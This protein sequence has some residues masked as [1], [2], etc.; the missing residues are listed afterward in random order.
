MAENKRL[1]PKLLH[2]RQIAG[3]RRKGIILIDKKKDKLFDWTKGKKIA[4]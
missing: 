2:K 4:I 3:G 1:V